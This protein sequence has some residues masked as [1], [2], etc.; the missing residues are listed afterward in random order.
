M[1]LTFVIGSLQTASLLLYKKS[2]NELLAFFLRTS[3]AILTI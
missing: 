1:Y 3:R 2:V